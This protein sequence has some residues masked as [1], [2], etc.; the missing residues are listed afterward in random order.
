MNSFCQ[1]P[2]ERAVEGLRTAAL[3]FLLLL[4]APFVARA[5]HVPAEPTA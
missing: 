1:Q 3:S 5:Q 2:S 4:F